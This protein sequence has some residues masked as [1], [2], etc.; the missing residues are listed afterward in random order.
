MFAA[1]LKNM[2]QVAI[3][4]PAGVKGLIFDLDGTLIDSMPLHYE[5]YNHCLEPWGV[6]YP[7]ELFLSRGGIPTQDT[8][9][10]IEEENNIKDFDLELAL[11]RKRTFVDTNLDK[12]TLIEPVFDIVKSYYGKLPMAIGTGSNRATVTEMFEM[13]GLGEYI[14]HSV[15]ATEVE[16]YKPHPETFLKCAELIRVEPKDC[17]VF[18]DGAPGMKAARDAGMQ[19]VDVTQYL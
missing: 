17:V 13:F 10:L 7:K 11:E 14:E 12:I 1:K 18:E 15:T 8:L 4:I 6:H 2:E 9:L 5:A 16:N 3:P 19:L